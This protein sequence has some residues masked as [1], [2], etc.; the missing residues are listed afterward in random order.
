MLIGEGFENKTLTHDEIDRLTQSALSKA[1]LEGKRVLIIIPDRTRTAPI[2]LMFRL[3]H[4]HLRPNVAA[5]DY[6]IALGTHRIMSE[7]AINDL[8]GI[9]PAERSGKYSDIKILNH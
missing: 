1:N 6:L 9:T 2:P 5:L 3:L 4:K 7:D 8:V